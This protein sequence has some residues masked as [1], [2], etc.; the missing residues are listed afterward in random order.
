MAKIKMQLKKLS[1][2]DLV[3]FAQQV[4]NKTN[5]NAA[6]A[7][8][9]TQPAIRRFFDVPLPRDRVVRAMAASSSGL[10]EAGVNAIARWLKQ[11]V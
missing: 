10:I 8:L 4:C 7:A 9:A 11:N 1:H 5:S 3:A 2:S 6:F